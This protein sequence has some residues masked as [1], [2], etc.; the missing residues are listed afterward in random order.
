MEQLTKIV[1]FLRIPL[2]WS[3]AAE[4]S[5][6]LPISRS[7]NCQAL[8]IFWMLKIIHEIV[9]TQHKCMHIISLNNMFM[10]IKILYFQDFLG[11]H[12]GLEISFSGK[13]KWL[14]GEEYFLFL[15][16]TYLQF[17]VPRSG[18]SSS[19]SSFALSWPLWVLH[20]Q[21]HKPIHILLNKNK[22]F[23]MWGFQRPHFPLPCLQSSH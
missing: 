1:S 22:V 15:Q 10:L 20:L 14:S 12:Q 8:Y 11:R 13:E 21:V 23:Q 3:V 7:W 9:C 2:C 6:G 17:L 5:P 16:R 4:L 18:S 19:R